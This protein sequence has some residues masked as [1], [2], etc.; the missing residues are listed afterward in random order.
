MSGPGILALAVTGV[1]VIAGCSTGGALPSIGSGKASPTTSGGR[2]TTP[3]ASTGRATSNSDEAPSPVGTGFLDNDN[4]DAVFVQWTINGGVVSGTMDDD[5]VTGT[6]PS[7]QVSS[8]DYTVTG[9]LTGEQIILSLAGGP[10]VY[11]TF[12]NNVL[13]LNLPNNNGTLL[14]AT[15]NPATPT[16]F[17]QAVQRLYAK[18][19][20]DNQAAVRQQQIQQQI[21]KEEGVINQAATTA[22]SDVNS[23]NNTNFTNELNQL[24]NDANQVQRDLDQIEKDQKQV[25]ND[26]AQNSGAACGDLDGL[27]GGDL[28]GLMGGDLHGLLAGDENQLQSQ[29]NNVRG[30]EPT[31]RTDVA[32][33][34]AAQAKLPNY[35]PQNTGFFSGGPVQV[36]D[37][38]SAESHAQTSI[39]AAISQGNAIIGQANSYR[40][41]AIQIDQETT[42]T[43]PSCGETPPSPPSPVG[44]L[45]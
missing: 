21:Q 16:D 15:F 43:L 32:T 40:T 1:L 6:A 24:Q 37:V 39:A 19:Q 22:S 17:N 26:M 44:G 9:T 25:E 36:G 4:T 28:D 27:M 41:Q 29:I 11:G 34:Q 45:S 12:S 38:S 2:T 5:E 8:N 42:S 10:Q 3:P 14:A 7:E 20:N 30:L 31:A 33:Y 13:T 23:L 35:Q 18:V